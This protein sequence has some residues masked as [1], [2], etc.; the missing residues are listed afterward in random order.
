[1]SVE[2]IGYIA[3]RESSEIIPPTGPIID[4]D[5]VE[6]VA[7][8]HDDGGFDRALVAFHST[9]PES[10]LIAAHAASVTKKLNLMIA[11][12]PGFTQPTL[13]ARQFATLDQLTRGRV[14]VHI[15]TGGDDA[16]QRQD[17]DFLGKEQRYERTD[18]YLEVVRKVWTNDVPFNHHG[19][20]YRF[21]RAFSTVKAWQ[22]PHIPVYFG[23]ALVSAWPDS[24]V[25]PATRKHHRRL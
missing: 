25:L 19:K 17:G 1:M 15:I 8:A 9:S 11:H 10:I 3:T 21:E 5:H 18:E 12:R 16:E 23:G 24:Q 2:F 4:L 20:Y 13:A 14:G 22:K 6:A 7:R